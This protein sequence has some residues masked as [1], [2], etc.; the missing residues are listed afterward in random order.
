MGKYLSLVTSLVYNSFGYRIMRLVFG[1]L[2]RHVFVLAVLAH[3]ETDDLATSSSRQSNSI[4]PSIWFIQH[5]FEWMLHSNLFKGR[6][7][8]LDDMIL[9]VADGPEIFFSATWD[10]HFCRMTTLDVECVGLK[11]ET[12]I[13]GTSRL[14]KTPTTTWLTIPASTQHTWIF[15]I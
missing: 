11:K 6:I 4:M 1:P 15:Y 5:S 14:F 12:G 2:L 7:P 3:V 8:V 10:R 9:R 13:H